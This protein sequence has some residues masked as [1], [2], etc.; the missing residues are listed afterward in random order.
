[1]HFTDSKIKTIELHVGGA[2]LQVC[3]SIPS[4]TAPLCCPLEKSLLSLYLN[5]E[6][7]SR[8]SHLLG[9]VHIDTDHCFSLNRTAKG[10][11]TNNQN[12][13]GNHD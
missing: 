8:T 7:F 2:C 5:M 1:M 11:F 4:L 6:F 13:G 12:G 9:F 10:E 3:G